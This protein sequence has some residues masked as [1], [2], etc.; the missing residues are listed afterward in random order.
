MEPQHT[1]EKQNG[2]QVKNREEKYIIMN[3]IKVLITKRRSIIYC[4]N[5]DVENKTSSQNYANAL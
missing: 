1:L 3:F 2:I 5:M 4:S